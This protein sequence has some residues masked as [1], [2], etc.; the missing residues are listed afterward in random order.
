MK[1][2]HGANDWSNEVAHSVIPVFVD[3]W[4]TGC[5]PCR[6]MEPT[7]LKMEVEFAGKVKFVKI[8]AAEDENL[9]T[10]TQ[11]DVSR[12]PTFMVF[13][14]GV[15]TTQALIGSVSEPE[16]RQWIGDAIK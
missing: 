14:S 9:S 8:N 3:F 16:L 7:I 13:K 5:G 4:S 15:Q 10:F 2:I 1:E 6:S 11:H 12:V